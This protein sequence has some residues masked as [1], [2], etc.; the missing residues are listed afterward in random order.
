MIHKIETRQDGKG[1]LVE[2]TKFNHLAAA[3]MMKE[4][5]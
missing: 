1:N 4:G 2:E 3:E 5:N